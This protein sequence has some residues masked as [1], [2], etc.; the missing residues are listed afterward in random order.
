[1]VSATLP[2]DQPTP[3]PDSNNRRDRVVNRLDSARHN[4]KG[5]DAELVLPTSAKATTV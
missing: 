2:H 4:A 5:M 1:M 3:K